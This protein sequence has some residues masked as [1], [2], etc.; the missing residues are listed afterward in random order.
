MSKS[1]SGSFVALITPFRNKMIDET[2]FQELVE[3][4]ISQGSDG[5]VPCGTTGESPTLSHDEHQRV[6][7]LTI[8]V[9]GGR[10]PVIAG[11]GS[12]S[13]EEAIQLTKHAE[14]ADAD[15]ALVVMPYYNKPTQSGMYAHFKAINDEVNIPIFIYNIPS[16]SVVDMSIK[17]M[18]ELAK[19]KN[20]IGVKDASNDPIRPTN[21]RISLD[22]IDFVQFSGED[23][24][25]LGFMAAGGD[26]IISVTAN[27]APKMMSDFHREWKKGNI[28]VARSIQERLMPLHNALFLE[29]SPAP[30]KYAASLLD[31][32][33]SEVRLPLVE[34][35]QETK[36][37]LRDALE[38]LQLI[39]KKT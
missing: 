30:V 39:S 17:T 23:P 33:N 2:K 11:T 5:L 35:L 10:V 12:N 26:G 16:R 25:Q 37:K 32:C 24:S 36:N 13:T 6:I 8:E 1:F 20:I 28:D 18:V 7:D 19:L 31:I 3:W 29:T 9:A 38:K 34:P 4:Q 15:A 21:L 14:K 27:V 22:G